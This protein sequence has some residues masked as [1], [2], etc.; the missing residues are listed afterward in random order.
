MGR[1]KLNSELISNEKSRMIT[2]QKRKK[3]LIKKVEE[4][5]I[6]CNVDVCVII[7]GPKLGHRYCEMEAWPVN[8][9]EVKRIINMYRKGGP[10]VRSK[11]NQDLS[12]YFVTRKNKVDCEIEKIQKAIVETK[13]SKCCSQLRFLSYDQ[14][15]S[16]EKTLAAKLEVAERRLSEMENNS[17]FSYSGP[18]NAG[19]SLINQSMLL[20]PISAYSMHQKNI[21]FDVDM[22]AVTSYSYDLRA[23]QRKVAISE[24]HVDNAILR[25]LVHSENYIPYN[26]VTNNNVWFTPNESYSDPYASLPEA[27]SLF[28]KVAPLSPEMYYRPTMQSY[29]QVPAVLNG[30]SQMCDRGIGNRQVNDFDDY[31]DKLRV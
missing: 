8:S 9:D 22:Q 12:D 27:S 7:F 17:G 28:N 14:L 13:F 1:R 3:G 24:S 11:K 29:M 10:K 19:P 6:L 16:L 5:K 23:V 31:I 15:Y 26:G 2:F 21:D 30:S 18:N 25:L 20:N 4:L